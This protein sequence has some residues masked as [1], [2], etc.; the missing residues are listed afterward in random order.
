MIDLPEEAVEAAN[1]AFRDR[2]NLGRRVEAAVKAAAPAIRKQERERMVKALL[3]DHIVRK[4]AKKWMGGDLVPA[5]LAAT[6][7]ARWI[8]ATL[9]DSDG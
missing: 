1:A 4:F 6:D 3:S 5:G 9:E 8:K 2:E 7:L